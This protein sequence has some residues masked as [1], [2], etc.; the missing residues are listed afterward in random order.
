M[1]QSHPDVLQYRIFHTYLVG[2]R[3]CGWSITANWVVP[4]SLDTHQPFYSLLLILCRSKQ[5]IETASPFVILV[6]LDI[7]DENGICVAL[8]C[9]NLPFDPFALQQLKEEFCVT[10]S[11]TVAAPDR[12]GL[13]AGFLANLN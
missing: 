5:I 1:G 11:V 13:L 8:C 3:F 7:I 9:L 4:V 2:A 6:P 12:A 10:S